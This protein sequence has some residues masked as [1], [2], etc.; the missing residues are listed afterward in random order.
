MRSSVCWCREYSAFLLACIGLHCLSFCSRTAITDS[1]LLAR[2]A[3]REAV[4][5]LVV[6]E[7]CSGSVLWCE[8]IS[9]V[10]FRVGFCFRR[11]RGSV[12]RMFIF[13]VSVWVVT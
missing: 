13:R 4:V 6:C 9:S 12:N 2:C 7:E 10:L 8:K 3:R 5:M 11:S 1:Q